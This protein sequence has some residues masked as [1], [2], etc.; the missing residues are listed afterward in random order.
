MRDMSADHHDPAAQHTPLRAPLPAHGR[1]LRHLADAV[2]AMVL[3]PATLGAC[4]D[5]RVDDG[6]PET[7]PASVPVESIDGRTYL[8]TATAGFDLVE[9]STVRMTFADGR[10]TVQAGCNSIG[11]DI[12]IDGATLVTSA[13]SMTEMGCEAPLM[14]QDQL[15]AELLSSRPILRLEGEVLVVEGETSSITFLDR[16]VADP[17]RPLEQTTWTL[18]GVITGDA[19][20]SAP[21]DAV[22]TLS[23]SDGTALVATGC[24]TGSAPVTIEGDTLSFGPLAMTKMACDDA[25]MQLESQ[26][27]TVLSG[28]PTWSIEAAT[29]TIRN[30]ADG[31]TFGVVAG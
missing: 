7:V 15:I 6:V 9:N 17:D 26:I 5:E 28:T 16:E 30:G 25:R 10:V 24:N 2:L 27:V 23:I 19:V 20:S 8:S 29:L 12:T 22:A 11:G 14:E 13:L 18:T 4:G 31:L 21:A 1:V 3:A